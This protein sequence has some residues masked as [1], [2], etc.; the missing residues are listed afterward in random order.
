MH[1]FGAWRQLTGFCVYGSMSSMRGR[2]EALWLSAGRGHSHEVASAR[3]TKSGPA[4][5]ARADLV[6]LAA[7]CAPR[8]TWRGGLRRASAAAIVST[9][10]KLRELA[11]VAGPRTNA[12]TPRQD[13]RASEGPGN[14][15]HGGRPR[16][17][18]FLGRR[19]SE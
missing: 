3:D 12:R 7:S 15:G 11:Q 9:S 8:S 1:S 4:K 19:A 16:G 17:R 5:A 13:A 18:R 10:V 6:G 14:V 2:S